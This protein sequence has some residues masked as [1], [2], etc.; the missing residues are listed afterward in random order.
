MKQAYFLDVEGLKPFARAFLVPTL[1]G[2]NGSTFYQSAASQTYALFENP[3]KPIVEVDWISK[4]DSDATCT[5]SGYL[6]ENSV[7]A[8]RIER[9]PTA[10]LFKWSRGI[11]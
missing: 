7:K 4:T 10:R 2:A 9:P 1:I 5:I 3:H 11:G 6:S 8:R